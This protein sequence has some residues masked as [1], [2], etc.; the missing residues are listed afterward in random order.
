MKKSF[1]IL[2]LAAAFLASCSSD[3]SS[4][5]N[6]PVDGGNPIAEG[7]IVQPNV[8]GPNQPNQVY[9]D[10]SSGQSAAVVRTSWDLGFYSG[11]EFR[12]VLNTSLKMAVK[13]LE[14]TNIDEVQEADPSV[15]VSFATDATLGYVDNP[16]GIL[17]GNGGGEGTAIAEISATDSENKVYLVNMGLGLSTTVPTVGSVNVDGA[18]R[19]WKKIRILRSGNDYKIQYA[20]LNATTH[21][22]FTISKDPSY[23][24][25]FFSMVDNK[26][27]SVEPKKGDWDLNFTTFTNYYP[28]QGGYVLYPFADYTLL[29]IKGGTRVYEIITENDPNG[30]EAAYNAFALLNV[31]SSRFEA[32]AADHRFINWR[33]EAGP[34]TTMTVKTDRFYILKDSDGNIYKVLFR[35]LKNDLGERGHPIFEYKLLK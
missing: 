33:T 26:V 23:N 27:T 32:S 8:G 3:D 30:G 11:P 24:F 9:I 1:F 2:F 25:T 21:Q 7:S 31:E 12:V 5:V 16:T 28:Y 15:N 29:N 10:F 14:T 6:P 34:N 20:D 18:A 19:G 17:T 4:P 13:K 35:A 22:E